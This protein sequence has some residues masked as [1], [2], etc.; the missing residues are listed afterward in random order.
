MSVSDIVSLISI[1][2]ALISGGIAF[3][4][5]RKDAKLKRAEYMEKLIKEIR[6]GDKM[7]FYLFEYN[8]VWYDENFHKGGTIEQNVDYTLSYLS[9][10]CYLYEQKIISK[11]EFKFFEYELKR[12]LTNKQLQ[13]YI[14][15]VYHFSKAQDK[16]MMFP[17]LFEYAK[18]NGYI[19]N[20]FWNEKSDE[21][22]HYLNF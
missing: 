14:Y 3:C 1:L 8:K 9:F 7:Q 19:N 10:L 17:Y 22:K 16:P 6:K 13:N 11:K 12:I 21:Y 18:K 5:W 2:I 4:K 20:E 15:N